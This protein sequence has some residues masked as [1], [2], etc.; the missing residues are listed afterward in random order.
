[1]LISLTKQELDFIFNTLM[2]HNLDKVKDAEYKSKLNLFIDAHNPKKLTSLEDKLKEDNLTKEQ[3]HENAF[4][5]TLNYFLLELISNKQKRYFSKTQ[6]YEFKDD[7]FYLFKYSNFYHI[8]DY[9]IS[10]QL[11]MFLGYLNNT[12]KTL[13]EYDR[14]ERLSRGTA[15][16]TSNYK[17]GLESHLTFVR[18]QLNENVPYSSM[19]KK[20]EERLK[21]NRFFIK[22]FRN[23]TSIANLFITLNGMYNLDKLDIE[24]SEGERQGLKQ[25]FSHL[26]GLKTSKEE[27]VRSFMIKAYFPYYQKDMINK[28]KLA[29]IVHNMA[30]SFFPDIVYLRKIKRED[31]RGNQLRSYTIG[32]SPK[33]FKYK[34][35]IKT[36]LNENP[37]YAYDHNKEYTWLIKGSVNDALKLVKKMYLDEGHAEIVNNP[38]FNK[39]IKKMLKSPIYPL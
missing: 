38:L 28:T 15:F 35:Y 27:I 14:D 4:K 1:M 26:N 22:S 30:Q 37:I 18:K 3:H 25:V 16:M 8:D 39:V 9:T 7:I 12:F 6:M 36:A 24:C 32:L 19:T 31:K 33:V 17:D 21:V 20:G 5:D 23:H 34:L 10:I 13:E 29:K 11:Y 2:P